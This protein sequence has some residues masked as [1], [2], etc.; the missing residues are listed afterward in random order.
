MQCEYCGKHSNTKVIIDFGEKK[1]YSGS[2]EVCPEC[3]ETI[4]SISNIIKQ[5]KFVY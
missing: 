4:E 3:A 1:D 5:N 2:A